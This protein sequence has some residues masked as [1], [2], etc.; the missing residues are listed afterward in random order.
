MP[1][2]GATTGCRASLRPV[3]VAVLLAAGGGSRFHG[4]RHKLLSEIG[5]RRLFERAV[6]NVVASGISPVVVVT[7]AV[8]L[9]LPPGTP[10]G[11]VELVHNARWADGQATSLACA[12]DAAAR[13]GADQ[14]VV[15]LADQ[16]GIDPAAWRAVAGAPPEWQIVVA[17]YDGRRG[18]HPVRMN[19]SVWPMLTRSGDDG[20]RTL[21][22]EH[23]A[24]V[25]EVPCPGSATDID[26][27]E[28]L[29]RW[30]SS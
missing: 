9:P 16:P 30:T 28:D 4:D 27:L 6:G 22:R 1:L 7:G 18:P 17:S 10:V 8:E 26:T 12:V 13:L 15:G 11:S 2:P 23:P 3:I 5:G 24:L 21:I 25:H 19:R 20:A 14:V 29:Q